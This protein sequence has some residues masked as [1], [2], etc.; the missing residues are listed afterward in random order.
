MI[1]LYENSAP[2]HVFQQHLFDIILMG[3]KFILVSKEWHYFCL[4]SLNPYNSQQHE[5]RRNL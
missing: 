2:D 1:N 4:L 5:T 3:Y